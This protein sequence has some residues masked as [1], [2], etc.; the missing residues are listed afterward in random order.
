MAKQRIL[1][2]AE[3]E[4]LLDK[5]FEEY[6]IE[7]RAMNL[8]KKTI[9][10]Y[11]YSMKHFLA[12]LD[13]NASY[14]NVE[15][16]TKEVM[17]IW[18]NKLKDKGMKDVTLNGLLAHIR[19]FIY[20]CMEEERQYISKPYK[21]KLLKEQE[22]APKHFTNDEVAALI[23]KPR[24]MASFP[25]WRSWAVVSFILGTGARASTVCNMKMQDVDFITREIT[26][27]HTKN[28][29]ALIV[30]LSPALD[31]VLREYIKIW[32]KTA[33]PEALLFPTRS[34]TKLSA[35]SLWAGTERFFRIRGVNKTSI[36]GLRH[37]FAIGWVRNNG[38]MFSL[39]KILGHST[40]DMTRKYVK[41]FTEDIKVNF[42]T[43]NPLDTAKRVNSKKQQV[44]RTI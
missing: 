17:F 31:T 35:N 34:N 27:G 18:I 29:K 33:P 3:D 30:P 36:H 24:K 38:N 28:N 1:R 22:V 20:W 14:W 7:K 12:D 15:D 39:Q 32:R 23:E 41:L 40:L 11:E 21:I 26:L 6:L 44:K 10:D 2:A 9:S 42:E 37:T 5:A 19:T 13:I 4:V 43:Y 25:E 16:L 8:S